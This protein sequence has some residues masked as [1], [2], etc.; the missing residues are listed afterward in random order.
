MPIFTERCSKCQQTSAMHGAPPGCLPFE[1][2]SKIG[3]LAAVYG[4]RSV[5]T[6]ITQTRFDFFQHNVFTVYVLR[7][8]KSFPEASALVF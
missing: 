5:L 3:R 4:R 1:S 7:Q 8:S 2:G 6:S